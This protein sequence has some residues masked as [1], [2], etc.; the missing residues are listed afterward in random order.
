MFRR[1]KT[2]QTLKSELFPKVFAGFDHDERMHVLD[3]GNGNASTLEFLQPFGGR[4]FFLDLDNAEDG[5]YVEQLAT[6]EESLFDVCLFW[7]LLHCLDRERLAALNDALRPY[8]YSQTKG[9]SVCDLSAAATRG[10]SAYKILDT[11]ELEVVSS[12]PKPLRDWSYCEFVR[13]F[14]S[15]RVE[16]DCLNEHGHLELLLHAE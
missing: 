6:Y 7:D 9:Y 16:E 13:T 2:K 1:A 11:D 3:V 4:V 10:R 15:F 14:D 8:V 12:S 5:D